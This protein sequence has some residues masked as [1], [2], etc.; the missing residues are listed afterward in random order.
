MRKLRALFMI[1]C[2]CLFAASSMTS[3]SAE[4]PQ[5]RP[6]QPAPIADDP[7][8]PCDVTCALLCIL[9]GVCS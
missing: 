1:A 5:E 2:I 9:F 7:P 6:S 3:A 8:K 4:D